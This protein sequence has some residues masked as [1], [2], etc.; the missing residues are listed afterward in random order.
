M[1][2]DAEKGMAPVVDFCTGKI[3]KF[4]P[5]ASQF[6]PLHLLIYNYLYTIWLFNYLIVTQYSIC[7]M[8]I[9]IDITQI[10]CHYIQYHIILKS[11]NIV[12]KIIVSWIRAEQVLIIWTGLIYFAIFFYGLDVYSTL[13]SHIKISNVQDQYLMYI[14]LS[15]VYHIDFWNFRKIQMPISRW[16][17][18]VECCNLVWRIILLYRLHLLY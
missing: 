5:S 7:L 3:D 16:I 10:H 17:L 6:R 9:I 1:K 13:E 14:L 11:N 4:F 8:I 15:S 2:S 18:T 12:I